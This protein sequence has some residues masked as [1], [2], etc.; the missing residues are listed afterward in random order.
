MC[1][2]SKG[3]GRLYKRCEHAG[4][5]K[6]LA[7]SPMNHFTNDS[8]Q[9]LA[10]RCKL[11]EDAIPS[12]SSVLQGYQRMQLFCEP[13]PVPADSSFVNTQNLLCDLAATATLDRSCCRG[14][15][16]LHECLYLFGGH[17]NF[18]GL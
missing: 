6:H 18:L 9:M 15:L 3:T 13:P 7:I 11:L 2:L 10:S 1:S 17:P 5:C 16:S 8:F 12:N 14:G 4:E